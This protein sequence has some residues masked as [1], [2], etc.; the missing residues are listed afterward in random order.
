VKKNYKVSITVT[1]T[2]EYQVPECNSPEEAESI[3][4]AYFADGDEGDVLASDV[5]GIDVVEDEDCQ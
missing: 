4:E 2:H 1:S 5:D 3:A